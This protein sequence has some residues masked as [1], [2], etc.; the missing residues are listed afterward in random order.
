MKKLFILIL[1]LLSLLTTAQTT[2]ITGTAPGAEGK[3]IEVITSSDLVTGLEKTLAIAIVDST[4]S[5]TLSLNT[6]KTLSAF[7]AIDFH[8]GELYIEPGKSYSLEIAPLNYNDIQEVNPFVESQSLEIT[9]QG[10]NPGDLNALIQAFNKEYNVFVLE[11]FNY[12]YQEKDKARLDTFSVRMARKFPDVK[13]AY[14]TDYIKYK[15]GSLEQ[16]ANVMGKSPMVKKYFSDAPILYD[17]VEYMD[18]FNEFFSKY[19]TT[20]SRPLKF[21]NYSAMLN[22][23]NSY[24]ALMKALESDT[25]LK[26]PQLRE[27]VLLRNLV[28]M[29][30]DPVYKQESIQTTLAAVAKDSKFAENKGIAENLIKYLTRLRPGSAAPGFK[31]QDRNHRMVSLSDFKGKPVLLGFWTTYCQS[32]LSEM[33]LLKPLYDKYHDRMAFVSISADREFMK[34]LFFLNLKKDFSWTFLHLGDEIGLLRDYD[35][36]S[37]PLFVLID[38]QGRIVNYPAD[39][40]GSGLESSLEKLLN[41]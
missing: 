36:R 39:L 25:L 20:T 2:K 9:I 22:G 12:L 11:N 33:E 24:P 7:L 29:Y 10:N 5:F 26:R 14:F 30:D 31:L 4:A 28:E 27:L 17:N 15:L 19:I 38:S 21:L 23:P 1:P 32:C 3:K 41:P 34:M 37:Y 6:D 40:P 13:K 8:R 35:V 18:F 16:V